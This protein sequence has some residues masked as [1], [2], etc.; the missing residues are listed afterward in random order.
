M[1]FSFFV[2]T[3][4]WQNNVASTSIKFTQG[5]IFLNTLLEG[6]IT[7]L[8]CNTLLVMAMVC[9]IEICSICGS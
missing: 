3:D 6:L 4:T 1:P 5:C 7:L 9:D 8:C 2:G